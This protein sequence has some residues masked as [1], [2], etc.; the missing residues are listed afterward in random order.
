MV[1]VVLLLAA[2]PWRAWRL[3]AHCEGLSDELRVVLVIGLA[4]LLLAAAW[5]SGRRLVQLG[6]ALWRDRDLGG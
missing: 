6:R 5:R 3:R 4:V 1:A 2:L